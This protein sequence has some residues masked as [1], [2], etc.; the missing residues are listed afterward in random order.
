M[1]AHYGVALIDDANKNAM[2]VVY[3]L[4]KGEDPTLSENL[5]QAA[6]ATGNENDPV[7]HWFGGR[8]YTLADLAIIQNLPANMPS[9]SW[10]VTGVSGSVSLS[11]AQDAATA[12]KM[13]VTSQDAFTTQQAQETLAA[14]LTAKNLNRVT[15]E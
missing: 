6:N 5:S 4:W 10:P 12:L 14:A 13:T 11:A 2:N 1:T 7:T 15:Y 9:A 3:A 8:E